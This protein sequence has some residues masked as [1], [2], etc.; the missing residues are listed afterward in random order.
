MHV[1]SNNLCSCATLCSETL[2]LS[3]EKCTKKKTSEGKEETR[4][5]TKNMGLFSLGC[6]I[7]RECQH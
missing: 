4:R 5:G 7:Y 6:H 3:Q 2:H 1:N